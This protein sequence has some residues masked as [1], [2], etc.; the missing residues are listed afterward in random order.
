MLAPSD[1]LTCA[2]RPPK[3]SPAFA[4]AV[5]QIRESVA[6]GLDPERIARVTR[7]KNER[8]RRLK[9]AGVPDNFNWL[10]SG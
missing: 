1:L 5:R 8:E 9:E 2:T 3:P 10:E 4:E 6:T 7:E